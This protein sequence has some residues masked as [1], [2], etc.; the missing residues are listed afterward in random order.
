[1]SVVVF[2]LIINALIL[3]HEL[4]HFIFAKLGRVKVK[5][6]SLGIGPALLSFRYRG[7]VFKLRAIP[8]GGFNDIKGQEARERGGG[9]F[10]DAPGW[11]KLAILLG[12]VVFNLVLGIVLLH[13]Y[14]A[15]VGYKVKVP[16]DV[17]VFFA[18][19]RV[20]EKEG[21]R[22]V[23]VTADSN[24][25]VM[26][27]KHP[28]MVILKVGCAA[29]NNPEDLV[30]L[31]DTLHS[32]GAKSVR[33]TLL[34]DGKTKQVYGFKLTRK[35]KLGVYIEKN[36]EYILD[37]SRHKLLAGL[38]YTAD[39]I[40]ANLKILYRLVK[41]A[42]STHKMGELKY[43]VSGPVGVYKVV[44]TGIKESLGPAYF[45]QLIGLL[46]VSLAVFNLLP[47]PGLDGWHVLI[48]L[49]AIVSGG[50]LYHEKLYKYITFGGL[51]LLIL[52]SII[53]TAKDIR[54]FFLR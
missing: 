36:T 27:K 31:I 16:V 54:L 17:P 24:M 30:K 26:F 45:V 10:I 29:V 39:L 3:V 46:S 47:I 21:V 34:L 53:I 40:Y 44:D 12:G 4:G 51:L 38:F 9:N 11:V 22:V 13:I 41:T 32:K 7:T 5:E 1:M 15:S 19:K 48:V 50:R 8:F 42:V 52:L 28:D 35:G 23:G 14:V 37:Y 18:Q 33:L 2:L 25:K 20:N 6:F 43:A 49:L